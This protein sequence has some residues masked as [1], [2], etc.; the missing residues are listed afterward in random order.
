MFKFILLIFSLL[1]TTNAYLHEF[2]NQ[3]IRAHQH[4]EDAHVKT[5]TARQRHVRQLKQNS[6]LHVAMEHYNLGKQFVAAYKEYKHR[7]KNH[8]RNPSKHPHP[9]GSGKSLAHR[10][11]THKGFTLS[12][13]D[14]ESTDG[15]MSVAAEK[16]MTESAA[17]NMLTAT[18]EI[19]ALA[20]YFGLTYAGPEDRGGGAVN[21][22]F[23]KYM[24]ECGAYNCN[25]DEK[26]I[27]GNCPSF[28]TEPRGNDIGQS[29]FFDTDCLGWGW[30]GIGSRGVSCKRL[31]SSNIG[32][33]DG[34]ILDT[35]AEK[36]CTTA[37]G[38]QTPEAAYNETRLNIDEPRWEDTRDKRYDRQGWYNSVEVNQL[39]ELVEM[40]K[41]G[42]TLNATVMDATYST[43]DTHAERIEKFKKK[44]RT[45]G[46]YGSRAIAL[47]LNK[48]CQRVKGNIK[49]VMDDSIIPQIKIGSDFMLSWTLAF[50]TAIPS[51]QLKHG[52]ENFIIY[53]KITKRFGYGYSLIHAKSAQFVGTAL[54]SKSVSLGW[55]WIFGFFKNIGTNDAPYTHTMAAFDGPT[56]GMEVEAEV[57]IP[58]PI[59][60]KVGVQLRTVY[61]WG[62]TPADGPYMNWQN[63]L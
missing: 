26:G 55:S 4:L 8:V 12:T 27:L 52:I 58:L 13:T 7:L 31:D 43:D 47:D 39:N 16:G 35:F 24:P 11:F 53:D 40:K 19:N 61:H 6:S 33:D 1:I 44:Y 57:A 48:W 22:K 2:K 18:L 25:V 20:T 10:G 32:A 46:K 17:L 38:K 60:I 5:L 21:G 34:V 23:K 28:I 62:S 14:A 45:F 15:A 59:Q 3:F 37:S 63:L 49:T 29:C 42:I 50:G 30:G 36:V 41:N 54:P 9:L 56:I 51:I